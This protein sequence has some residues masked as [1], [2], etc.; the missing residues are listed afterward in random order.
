[1]SA[2][3]DKSSELGFLV[4]GGIFLFVIVAIGMTAL[5]K[6]IVSTTESEQEARD[7]EVAMADQQGRMYR[8]EAELAREEVRLAKLQEDEEARERHGELVTKLEEEK[9]GVADLELAITETEIFLKGVAEERAA[10]RAKMR[11][12]LWPEFVNLE[13][14]EEHFA[15]KP[16]VEEARVLS[17]DA[18]GLMV[19]H[20][21]GVSRL[22][23]GSLSREFRE[24]LDL[25]VEEARK[26]L[27]E[28]LIR[29]AKVKSARVRRANRVNVPSEAEIEAILNQRSL[30][31]RAK[32]MKYFRL[33][34]RARE[35]ARIARHNDRY[36][37]NR[38]APGKLET[39]A[40]RA[41]RFEKAEVQYQRLLTEAVSEVRRTEP[42]FVIPE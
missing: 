42:D 16:P 8:Y 25:S 32:V 15:G 37:S 22:P 33:A 40:E 6:G 38:S 24:E 23:V 28:M 18:A 35:T 3:S 5:S 41:K 29:D 1:M 13:L 30:E 2:V 20:R 39:W 26:V 21:S 27:T 34:R 17:V 9:M 10:Y 36:A 12:R 19:R 11:R 4:F 7:L 31:G 14:N